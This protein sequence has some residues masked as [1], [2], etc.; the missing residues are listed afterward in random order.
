MPEPKN[1]HQ[2]ARARDAVIRELGSC[3][4]EQDVVQ[5][6]YAD[7]HPAFGYDT[8]TLQVLEREGWYHSLAVQ[9]GVL[10]DTRREQLAGTSLG[11]L[12]EQGRTSVL[13]VGANGWADAVWLQPPGAGRRPRLGIWVPVHRL[14]R[15][16][17][18]WCRTRS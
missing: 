10:Q 14:G 9:R 17:G 8:I 6:L 4:T 16:G 2:H 12:Y 1:R 18:A 3:A 15:P 7:L 11:D 13:D 5:V